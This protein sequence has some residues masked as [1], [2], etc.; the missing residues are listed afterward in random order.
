MSAQIEVGI[1]PITVWQVGYEAVIGIECHVQLNTATKAF[2]GCSNQYGAPPNSHVCPVCLGHP[3][4]STLM[5]GLVKTY[6]LGAPFARCIVLYSPTFKR[7]R[8]NTILLSRIL[9]HPLYLI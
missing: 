5:I 4:R 3:V 1:V 7:S 6:A 9:L 8:C 2:C